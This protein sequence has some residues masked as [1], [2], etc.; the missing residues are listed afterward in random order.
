MLNVTIVQPNLYL[1]EGK[2]APH[3]VN[4]NCIRIIKFIELQMRTILIPPFSG[5]S[6]KVFGTIKDT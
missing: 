6:M 4:D 5:Y 3:F 1:S 2:S